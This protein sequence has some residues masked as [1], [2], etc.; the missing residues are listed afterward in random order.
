MHAIEKVRVLQRKLYRAAKARPE[1]TFGVLYEK[2]Y[3]KE[4]LS[5]AWEQVRRNRGSAGV[6]DETIEDI[7][8]YGVDRLLEELQEELR[9]RRYRPCPVLRVFIPMGG[10]GRWGS[11]VYGIESFKRR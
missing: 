6:D 5:Y 4:V 10:R 1:R 2:V 9:A 8:A 7:E 11:R 3:S